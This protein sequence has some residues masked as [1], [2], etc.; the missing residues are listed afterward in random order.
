ME[1]T[2]K[3]IED[4]VKEKVLK[5]NKE[6]IKI[7]TIQ[8]TPLNGSQGF[9]DYFK[10]KTIKINNS[11]AIPSTLLG[12]SISSRCIDDGADAVAMILNLQRKRESGKIKIESIKERTPKISFMILDDPL[13][14]S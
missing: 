3:Q 13:K 6:E 2:P 5:F 10:N 14:E 11:L 4:L 9:L 8:P 7:I 12:K 1:L